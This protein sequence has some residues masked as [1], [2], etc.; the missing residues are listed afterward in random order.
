[1]T[2]PPDSRKSRPSALPLKLLALDLVGA[3]LAAIG[4][5]EIFAGGPPLVPPALRFPGYAIAFL[6][7]GA[8]MM[9]PLVRH[10]LSRGRPG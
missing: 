5:Y 6:I 2:Q 9:M 10:I 3:L 8:L 7:I 1:M 4:L